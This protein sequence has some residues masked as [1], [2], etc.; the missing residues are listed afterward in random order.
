LRDPCLY[1]TFPQSRSHVQKGIQKMIITDTA[2]MEWERLRVSS[3]NMRTS[4][5]LLREGEV[6]PGMGLYALLVKLHGGPDKFTAPRHRHNFSQIRVGLSGQMDFGPGLECETGEVGFFPGGAYYG[7]EEIDGAEY[8]LLQ[9]GREWVTRA[10]DKQAMTEL[11]EH[12]RFE[13]GLYYYHEDGVEK[14]IDGKRAVWEHVY[15]RPEVIRDPQYRSPIMM[16]PDNFDWIK[17]R[18]LSRK[19]LGHFTE[20]DVTI[21]VVRWDGSGDGVHHC[22]PD[23]TSLVFVFNGEVRIADTSCGPQTAI[24][25]DLG[26]NHDITGNAGAEAIA[27]DFPAARAEA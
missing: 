11:S 23:R 8:M 7:P 22:G 24:W 10:Q 15:G 2:A 17:D 26:E 9:W 21:E 5:K 18:G 16:T 27:I 19:T 25:S 12:G 3:R 1:G 14:S 4:R 6:L 20:D 13:H